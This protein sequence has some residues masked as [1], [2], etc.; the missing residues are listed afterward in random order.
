MKTKLNITFAE[1]YKNCIF[2]SIV[3][4]ISN[5]ANPFF[6][7]EQSWDG[8]NYSFQYGT[9]RGTITFDVSNHVLVGAAR[10]EIS[11]RRDWYPEYKALNLFKDA[12]EKAKLLAVNE[13]LEYLYDDANGV[14]M[15]MATVAFW[16][17]DNDIFLSD[18]VNDFHSNGG[19]FVLNI[20]IDHY[21]LRKFLA[22]Q[23]RFSSEE[24]KVAEYLFD[25]LKNGKLKINHKEVCIINK[26][27]EG[28]KECLESL[29][30]LGIS[31]E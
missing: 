17:E 20:A 6:S 8:I 7:Y 22:E 21:G 24:F 1:L 23:Y 13:A 10:E 30:E 18:K 5:L 4:A 19:E 2:S 26:R 3:H 27:C 14:S 31:I 29:G 16:N 28:Y 9:A 25:C 15:P 12:P 11:R